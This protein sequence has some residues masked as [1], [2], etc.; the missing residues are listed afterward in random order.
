M[1][2]TTF[3]RCRQWACRQGVLA[4]FGLMAYA[5]PAIADSVV[6]AVV[7]DFG[8]AATGAASASNELA[9]A[10]LVK[11]WQPDFIVTT[12]DNNYPSG[13]ATT[14]DQNIGQFYHEFIHPYTGRY[15]RGARVNRCASP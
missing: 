12:G 4:L 13:A 10:N 6:V 7:G 2:H 5:V 14:I 15:G 8:G 3:L 9:V 1:S 11:R